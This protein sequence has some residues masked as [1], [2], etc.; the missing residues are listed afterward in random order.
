MLSHCTVHMELQ[1]IRKTL[2]SI[3]SKKKCL[4]KKVSVQKR[5]WLEREGRHLFQTTSPQ[6]PV[7]GKELEALKGVKRKE[8]EGG[9]NRGEFHQRGKKG[10]TTEEGVAQAEV[11]PPG[12]GSGGGRRLRKMHRHP[13]LLFPAVL[14]HLKPEIWRKSHL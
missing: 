10:G 6:L 2:K 1:S 11:A 3:F 14:N 5:I 12:Q 8:E 4:F 13:L 7:A 9:G